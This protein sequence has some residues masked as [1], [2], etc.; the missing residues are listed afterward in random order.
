MG[1]SPLAD[2]SRRI[3]HGNRQS[4]RNA[5]VSGVVVHYNYGIDSYGEATNPNREVSANYWITNAGALLPNIDEVYRAWTS[6]AKGYPGGA[7][8]DHRSVTFEVSNAPGFLTSTPM[9]LISD[10]AFDTLA[11]AIADVF[12]RY[13]LGQVV[14]SKVR[15]VQVHKDFVDTSCPGPW[16]MARLDALIA[17]AEAYRTGGSIPA[18]TAPAPQLERLVEDSW[19]GPASVGRLQAVLGTVQDR[20]ISQQPTTTRPFQVRLAAV[21]YANKPVGSSAVAALQR[22]LGV[23][24]D[25][26]L[27]PGSISA[28]QRKLGFTGKDVDN[29]LGPNTALRIQKALNAGRLW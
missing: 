24:P 22:K 18:P 19:L 6:G 15:A 29:F 23:T 9:G 2:M 4:T 5:R 16:M 21:S 12:K 26:F 13:G 20:V 27:G 7:A 10:A 25:C 14:R 17:Q 1:F 8:A 3:P 28:W 11:R